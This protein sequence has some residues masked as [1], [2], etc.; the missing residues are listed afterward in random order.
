MLFRSAAAPREED[1]VSSLKNNMPGF[2]SKYKLPI[3]DMQKLNL[4]VVNIGPFGKDAHRFT[5]RLEKD[6]SF[7][8]AP[9][10]V[11]ETIVKLLK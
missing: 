8:V 3:E 2:G 11:Y 7:N 6:Y 1:A 4:P 5:E 9:K 10:L